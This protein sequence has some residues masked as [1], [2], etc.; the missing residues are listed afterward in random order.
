MRN[1]LLDESGY[2]ER[3]AKESGRSRRFFLGWFKKKKEVPKVRPGALLPEE[4]KKQI[5]EIG[6]GK[7]VQIIRIGFDGSIDDMPIIIELIDID[8]EGFTG[9][10]VNPERQM[11]ESAT[12]SV[13]YAKHGGGI[14]SFRYDDGD[15]KEILLS[16]DELILEEERN[17]DSLKEILTALDVGD[18]VLVAY[19]DPMEK[20]TLNAEGTILEK[21]SEKSFKI[22]IEKINHIE[23]EKKVTKQ[24]DVEK[25]LV[26]DI[27]LI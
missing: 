24:F 8:D 21:Q 3:V 12:K 25:D 5:Q 17:V 26:I 16:Q 11:I 4:V 15:I 13:V 10:V 7:Q 19:Y 27:E 22:S 23:L 6:V 9:R 2:L 18:Q 14:I 20:A 1:I